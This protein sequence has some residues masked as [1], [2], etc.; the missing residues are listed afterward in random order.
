MRSFP[1][2]RRRGRDLLGQVSY[3]KRGKW[4]EGY[5]PSFTDLANLHALE[6]VGVG[7]VGVVARCILGVGRC[8]WL[9]RCVFSALVGHGDRWTWDF[10]LEQNGVPGL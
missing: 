5:T 4:A 3:E 8:G 10:L 2:R 7:A 6:H 9:G 1:T